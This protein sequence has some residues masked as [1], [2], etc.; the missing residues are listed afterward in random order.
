MGGTGTGFFKFLNG[1]G[2]SREF[3]TVLDPRPHTLDP[4][5]V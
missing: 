3:E 4:F 5:V 1:K 2:G